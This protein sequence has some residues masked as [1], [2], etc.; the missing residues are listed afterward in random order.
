[1]DMCTWCPHLTCSLLPSS[2]GHMRTCL[3][4]T[5]LHSMYSSGLSLNKSSSIMLSRGHSS[6]SSHSST[7]MNTWQLVRLRIAHS[8]ATHP[9]TPR[10]RL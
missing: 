2:L 9:K 4:H 10:G 3:G 1:M 6:N 8:L 7:V 5:C